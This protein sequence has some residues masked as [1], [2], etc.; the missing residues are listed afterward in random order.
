M[1]ILFIS[2]F[3]E[4]A[5][6]AWRAKQMGHEVQ[7]HLRNG[8]SQWQGLLP[9]VDKFGHAL[10][11][12]TVVVF[13]RLGGGKTA[14]RLQA[15]GYKVIGGG[16]WQD[17]MAFEWE[18]ARTELRRAKIQTP[19]DQARKL[20]NMEL[21][22]T[23][24][25]NG[26]RWLWPM[27]V[28]HQWR[29]LMPGD[30]GPD[31]GCAAAWTRTVWTETQILEQTLL[32]MT[33]M[34]LRE[35]HIGPVNVA[36]TRADEHAAWEVYRAYPGCEFDSTL[37][38]TRRTPQLLEA[39]TN[40]DAVRVSAD[41]DMLKTDCVGVRVTLPWI[42]RGVSIDG[43]MPEDLPYWD[44]QD[45]MVDQ[46]GDLVTAGASN[47][48]GVCAGDDMRETYARL[49]SLR[50]ADKQYRTDIHVWRAP[51]ASADGE[52]SVESKAAPENEPANELH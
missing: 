31:V 26:E 15:Q 18:F 19:E 38:I 5:P 25:F 52:A 40:P 21:I 27:F 16:L 20:P 11:P 47:V 24:F 6:L 3:G 14:Q 50:I 43:I 13:D 4:I 28:T 37:L 30:V 7:I 9:R 49:A 32:R 12:G 22:L 10:T 23:G 35:K 17:K 44:L 1:K 34:L 8:S 29:R 51:S 39:L 46:S 41:E 42:K 33:R 2:S 45:V 36:V 48:L